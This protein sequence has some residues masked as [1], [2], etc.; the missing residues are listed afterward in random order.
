MKPT[1]TLIVALFLLQSPAALQ[2]ADATTAKQPNVLFIA[3]DDLN[4]WVGSPG[5]ASAGED[6]EHGPARETRRAVHARALRG[7]AVQSLARGGLQRKA[8]V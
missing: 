6:A 2:A 8:S 4:D 7:A 1:L 5:R 3:I